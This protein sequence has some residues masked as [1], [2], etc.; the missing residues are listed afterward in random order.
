MAQLFTEGLMLMLLG[1]GIVFTF[2]AMLVLAMNGMSRLSARL[3]PLAGA[4]SPPAVA[5]GA[6]AATG[7]AADEEVLVAVI[8]AAIRRYR[9]R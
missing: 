3:E 1:M 8:S 5:P 6:P 4:G 2:L 7:P 9:D